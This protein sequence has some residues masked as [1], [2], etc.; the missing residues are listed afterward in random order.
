MYPYFSNL[1]IKDYVVK[2]EM[3]LPNG[4][5]PSR[6]AQSVSGEVKLHR[7][8]SEKAK[9]KIKVFLGSARSFLLVSIVHSKIRFNVVPK[10][11]TGR[12]SPKRVL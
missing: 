6:V 1:M 2:S 9:A 5:W 10:I 8:K 11:I 4:Q 3:N 7:K 12:Y